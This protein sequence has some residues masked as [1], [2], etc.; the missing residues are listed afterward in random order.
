VSGYSA[1]GWT[2]PTTNLEIAVHALTGEIAARQG[3]YDEAIGHFQAAMQVEDQQ[4][5]T[6]P[7]DWYYPIRQSLGAVL[8]KAGKP[9][10]AERVYR[11]DLER[12]RENGWSLFGLAHA[13][14]AQGKSAEAAGVY[15][16][17][18]KA[19]A[20]ADVTLTASRF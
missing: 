6:E 10:D 14:E 12:F 8:L 4:L 5:Y 13:L 17:F 19:W 1:V 2:V 20:T 3:R 7:P 9:V 15:E 11:E 16:R 18:R